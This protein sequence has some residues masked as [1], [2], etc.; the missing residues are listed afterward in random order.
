MAVGLLPL[1]AYAATATSQFQVTATVVKN[2][3]VSASDLAFGNYDPLSATALAQTTT[4]SVTCT[5]GTAFATAL[6]QGTT[7]GA[8]FA[9]RLMTD[10]AAGDTLTYNLFTDAA[11]T[12]IWGDGTASTSTVAGTGTGPLL[13]VTQTV[14][15]QV[16]AQQ[17]APANSYSDTI[18]VTV[19]F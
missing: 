1:G 10:G 16:S 19:T 5:K 15:G 2:C 7:T 12:T 9:N 18:H 4:V 6:D 8:T 14:Y 13:P 17:N 11:H 3:K